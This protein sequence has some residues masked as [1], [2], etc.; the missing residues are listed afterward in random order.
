MRSFTPA[1]A[2][3]LMTATLGACAAPSGSGDAAPAPLQQLPDGTA[4][5]LDS[6]SFKGLEAG[7]GTGIR[8]AFSDG[9]VNGD[10]GCNRFFGEAKISEGRLVLGPI[11][12][13]KRACLGPRAESEQALFSALRQLDQAFM[14]NGQLRLTTA[15]GAELVFVDDPVVAE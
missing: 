4:W 5:R 15:D 8:M 2:A 11:A 14:V 13:S 6:S 10:S 1:L 3:L 12:S 7:A 9:K